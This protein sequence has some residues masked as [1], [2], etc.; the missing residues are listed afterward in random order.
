MNYT[1]VNELIKPVIPSQ[2]NAE[3]TFTMSATAN[4]GVLSACVLK[5]HMLAQTGVSL[6]K[7]EKHIC[8]L[9]DTTHHLIVGTQNFITK[10]FFLVCTI[11]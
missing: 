9:G 8:K 2:L 6:F 1:A 10:T 7:L 4:I 5:N 11:I 3:I